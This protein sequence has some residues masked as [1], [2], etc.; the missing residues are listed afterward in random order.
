MVFLF[1]ITF[2]AQH[3]SLEWMSS[4]LSPPKTNKKKPTKKQEKVFV[5]TLLLCFSISL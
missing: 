4:L 5:R 1:L 3:L 2:C